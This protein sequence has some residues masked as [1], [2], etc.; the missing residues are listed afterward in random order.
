[1]PRKLAERPWPALGIN[2]STYYRGR[3]KAREQ[4]ALAAVLDRPQWQIA[5][6]R[7]NLDRCAFAHAAMAAEL[8]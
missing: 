4:A 8:N 2:R 6:L 3:A 7:A 5:E 1:M